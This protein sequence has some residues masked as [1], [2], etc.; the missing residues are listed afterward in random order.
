META[1]I[2]ASVDYGFPGKTGYTYAR[3][4]DYFRVEVMASSLDLE[5]LSTRGLLGGR[6]YGGADGNHGVVGV[7][8]S[9]DYFAPDGF[10]VSSTAV[11]FGTTLQTKT[12]AAMT[13][14][15]TGLLGVGY[16]A[17]RSID[18]SDGR[19]LP[20][21]P[22]TAGTRERPARG[23]PARVVGRDGAGIFRQ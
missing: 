13:L 5:H 22:R 11:S 10:R 12:L 7:Y 18:G 3:P 15:T 8:G 1:S 16:T 21:R 19:D 20:L 14:Q 6:R 4:F 2:G 23:R 9:Y 17:T